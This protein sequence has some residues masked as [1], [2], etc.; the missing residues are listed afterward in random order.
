M[1]TNVCLEN[2]YV[3]T[4]LIVIY[5][6]I[7]LIP[8]LL[9]IR[10]GTPCI[11]LSP[12]DDLQTLTHYPTR[13]DIHTTISATIVVAPLIVNI[14][15]PDVVFRGSDTLGGTGG[16]SIA[17]RVGRDVGC[18]GAGTG[19]GCLVAGTGVGCGETVGGGGEVGA[20]VVGE[21]DGGG[22][23]GPKVGDPGVSV[24]AKDVGETVGRPLGA[25]VGLTVGD[26]V[27]DAVGDRVGALLGGF[28]GDADGL[29]VGDN[30]GVDWS[31]VQSASHLTSQG[32]PVQ[33]PSTV[34]LRKPTAQPLE[35]DWQIFLTSASSPSQMLSP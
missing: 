13:L 10:L 28:V 33:P 26:D 5:W 9:S 32:V 2:R 25:A 24:G 21:D 3:F 30:V 20:A 35:H 29:A 22:L 11:P 14:L 16:I 7:P 23:V 27:G 19:V 8:F 34:T 12:M 4:T 17:R 1:A 18:L 31:A 6:N 15:L